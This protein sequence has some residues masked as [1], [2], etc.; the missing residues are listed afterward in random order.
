MSKIIIP[1]IPKICK[2]TTSHFLKYFK[3]NQK[4]QDSII[5]LEGGLELPF[6]DTDGE[7]LFRQESNFHYLFGVKE[8][9]FYGI[10]KMDG[11]R[12]LFLPQ[13][14]E[15]LQIFLGPNLHPEDVKRMYGVEEAYYDSQIEE[16]LSKLNPSMIYLYAK[17]V[18]S[19]SGSQ[20]APIRTKAVYKYNTNE[21]ELHDVLFEART[22]KTKEEIDF[23]R[24]AINGTAEAHRACMKYCKPG[25]YEFELEAEFYRV[26]YGQ[27]GMRN[28]GYFPICAS[29]NKGAT[30][31]YGHA[32]HPN[33]KIMEDGEMVL[34]DVGTEC[35]RYATDLTL[36]YPING[37][38]TEQQKTIYNIVL[39][40]NRGCEAAM[41]PG[42][43]GY[44][45]HELFNKLMLKGLLEAG[46][47]KGDVEEMY[48]N[49][50]HFFFMPHGIG[51]LIG[52]DTHDVGGFNFGIPRSDNCSLKKGRFNRV[53]EAGNIYPVEPGIYFIPFFLERGFKNEQVKKY[54]VENE[55]RKFWNFGGVRIEDDVL[56]TEEGVEVLDKDIPRTVEEIEAFLKH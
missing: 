22:V 1:D 18:N 47:I 11:T 20:P 39:S 27:Y 31:H 48:K 53:F 43:K 2:S 16:V 41:K 52:I 37:K 6:Y 7:Y 14:P 54:L 24:L 30:M 23:M 45:I 49:D 17:G 50:V 15:T 19:D 56:V 26:A 28:F 51:H 44:N 25:M 34:M 3:A 55:I 12:I 32:G 8:A 40:C 4:P 46:L 38:F 35:H 9:G 5:F 33:R 36:T 13:L 29:G 21:T 42:V 10:V